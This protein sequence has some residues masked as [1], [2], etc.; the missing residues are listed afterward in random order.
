MT[1]E[2]GQDSV[3]LPQKSKPSRGWRR[4]GVA[5]ALMAT[6]LIVIEFSSFAVLRLMMLRARAIPKVEASLPFYREVPW[7][8]A[9][10]REHA[11]V[12]E[13]WF[14]SDPYGLWRQRP[15]AG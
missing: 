11:T 2:S 7:G 12:L 1:N 9:Y 14:G 8:A 3:S 15:F 10:W 4:A 13:S 6:A 5:M